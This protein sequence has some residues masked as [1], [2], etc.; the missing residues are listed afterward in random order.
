MADEPA[1]ADAADGADEAPRPT[2]IDSLPL[3]LIV[4]VFAHVPVDARLRCSE[5]CRGF[6][7]VL[8]TERSL[9]KA[10]D[11]SETSG[12]THE[13]TDA[14]LRCAAAKAGSALETLD[15]SDCRRLTYNT[16]L[17]LI[18]ANAES[19]R[20]LHV[21]YDNLPDDINPC[22]EIE[23]TLRAAP[24]LRALVADVKCSA[25][26][27]ALL[28]S[29]EGVFQRLRVR[30]LLVRANEAD[31]AALRAVAA[32]LAAHASPLSCLRLVAAQLGAADV[33][34]ALVDAALANRLVEFSF[35][36]CSLSR[37]TASSLVR[38]L[39][40]AALKRLNIYN[41]DAQ[42]LDV[43]AAA[44]L[45]GA[46]RR[47]GVLQCLTLDTVGLWRNGFAAVTLLASL[48]GHPSLRTLGMGTN[49]IPTIRA[50]CAGTALFALV[51]ANMPALQMLDVSSCR[52]GDAGL[53]PLLDALPRN[54]H[55]RLLDVADNDMSEAFA[56]DELLPA[57]RA[58]ASLM[59]LSA[60]DGVAAHEAEDFVT[61]REL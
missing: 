48:V 9:W 36:V 41:A 56:R 30:H 24:R 60:G 20:E 47:N 31:G 43:P 11:F 18:T 29:S 45:A 12:V 38:L 6:R 40:G 44:L 28:L 42:L 57:V 50:A 46:L 53:R 39:G 55:L 2:M 13:V 17:P 26:E 10:L 25:E 7:Y 14:L 3:A 58:N 23:S 51:A 19:L 21:S 34:D 8:A 54:T 52:L 22:V 32:A 59:I 5:V 4:R 61:Q 33:L 15:V 27:A 16:L 49:P 1:C 35:E 37:A